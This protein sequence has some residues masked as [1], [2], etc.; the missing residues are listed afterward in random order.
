MKKLI[1]FLMS[2]GIL[3]AGVVHIS[4]EFVEPEDNLITYSGSVAAFIDEDNVHLW[5]STLTVKKYAGDWRKIEAFGEVSVETNSMIATSNELD[6]DLQDKKGTLSGSAIVFLMNDN[7][8][9]L[10]N[11]LNFDLERDFY[12]SYERNTMIRKDVIATSN[13][14]TY[15]GST[16]ILKGDVKA[17][18]GETNLYGDRAILNLD[19]DLMDVK[20]KVKVTLEDA[21]ITG[22]D[23]VYDMEREDLHRI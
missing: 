5:A 12:S 3:Y 11:S 9:V 17:K 19:K 7:A 20:G 14:F 18:S 2:L 4:S 6:Y 10:T 13:I 23:L 22:K 1:V 8:T 16:M 15:D 21:T